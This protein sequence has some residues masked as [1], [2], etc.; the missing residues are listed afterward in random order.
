MFD[1]NLVSEVKTALDEAKSVAV[2]LPP[3][4]TTDMVA[5]ALGLFSPSKKPANLPKSAVAARSRLKTP[6]FLASTRSKIV[7][8]IKT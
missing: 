5:S 8:A 3:E 1:Q 4:P 7:L 2:L 6:T